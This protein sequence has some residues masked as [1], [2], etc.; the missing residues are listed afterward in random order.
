MVELRSQFMNF[1]WVR[2]FIISFLAGLI[3]FLVENPQYVP[4][5]MK[6]IIDF[7]FRYGIASIAAI[8]LIAGFLSL[9][10]NHQ[11]RLRWEHFE[12]E[13]DQRAKKQE[14]QS[15]EVTKSPTELLIEWIDKVEH[16]L[17]ISE[18]GDVTITEK[19]LNDAQKIILYLI[20]KRYAFELDLIDSPE[21][22]TAE[23]AKEAKIPH[24][25]VQGWYLPLDSVIKKRHLEIWER[26]EDSEDP[27]D[28]YQL[29]I[30]NVDQAF[31]YVT[32]D[33]D[34]PEPIHLSDYL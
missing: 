26:Y 24:M 23:I 7:V 3:F 27:F 15:D 4:D 30:D 32:G 14:S 29:D 2:S 12:E 9:Y 34:I 22:S 6:E 1:P 13:L 19:D 8:G 28:K 20:G 25:T 21:A 11:Q 33:E 17:W 16:F 10:Y 18:D 5:S 31:H